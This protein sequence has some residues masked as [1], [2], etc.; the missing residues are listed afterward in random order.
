[1]IKFI[2]T[3]GRLHYGWYIVAAGT[4]TIFSCLGLGRFSLGMLLPAMG[5]SLHLS[6]AQMGLLSTINFMGYLLAVLLCGRLTAH[7]GH[8]TMIGFALV[9]IGLAMCGIGVAHHFVVVVVLYG[10]AG[11][12]SACANIPIMALV[13][14]WFAPQKRGRAAGCVVIGSGLAILLCGQLI[15][16]LNNFSALGWRLSWL[17]LGTIVLCAALFCSIVLR[18]SPREKDLLPVGDETMAVTQ[19]GPK[20]K[21]PVTRNVP[22]ILHC[23]AIYFLFGFSYVIYVTFIVTVMVQERGFSETVAG[24]F[25]SWVGLLS[26][27]SGPLFGWVADR[28]GIKLSLI[29]VFL[30]QSMAYLFVGLD[31]PTLFLYFSI[32]CFGLVAWSIPSLITVLVADRVGVEQMTVAFGWVTFIFGIG[33]VLGPYF[34]GL[35]AESTG[36]FSLSFLMAA[37]M[38]GVAIVVSALLP[39]KNEPMV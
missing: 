18:N 22:A 10:L 31:L 39:R 28:Y 5:E 35:L 15:P 11:M 4:V 1:M 27:F 36:D 2:R 12:G 8:R 6:Y 21:E 37:A 24:E 3:A 14:I 30:I 23:G 9:L 26:L 33:Q 7:F 25:W 16:F 29:L 19:P 32:G 20:R 17:V 38:A 34:A 13:A